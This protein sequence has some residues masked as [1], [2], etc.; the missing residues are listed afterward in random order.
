MEGSNFENF[1]DRGQGHSR[2][3]LKKRAGACEVLGSARGSRAVAGGSPGTRVSLATARDIRTPTEA[4]RQAGEK[5]R[6]AAYAPRITVVAVFKFRWFRSRLDSRAPGKI[7]HNEA[8]WIL[9]CTC[10]GCHCIRPTKIRGDSARHRQ[11]FA[12]EKA[13]DA[14]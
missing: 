4:F 9:S 7:N 11:R 3:S 6:P 5:G 14:C 13:R 1:R 8:R 2:P 10:I 12:L